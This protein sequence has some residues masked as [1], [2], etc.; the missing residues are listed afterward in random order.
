MVEEL[1]QDEI[2]ALLSSLIN[3]E[4]DDLEPNEFENSQSKHITSQEELISGIPAKNYTSINFKSVNETKLTSIKIV[5]NSVLNYWYSFF[6]LIIREKINLELI[7]LEKTISISNLNNTYVVSL[8]NSFDNPA[9]IFIDKPLALNL[10]SVLLGDKNNNISDA[11]GYNFSQIEN[12]LLKKIFRDLSRYFCLG[13]NQHYQENASELYQISDIKKILKKNQTLILATFHL[14]TNRFSGRIKLLISLENLFDLIN[15]KLPKIN[16]KKS[17]LPISNENSNLIK[18]Q[19]KETKVDISFHLAETNVPVKNILDL[20]KGDIVK[21]SDS[22]VT[23]PIKVLISNRPKF[24]AKK[25]YSNKKT[26]FKILS[27]LDK[28]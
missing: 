12:S 8:I 1:S 7:N 23:D 11:E 9:F 3:R 18:E 24:L 20:K 26:Y 6:T 15:S 28:D 21:F 13:L 27:Q 2:D 19:M 10:V 17:L 5:L 4:D 22:F 16:E 14:N 25:N